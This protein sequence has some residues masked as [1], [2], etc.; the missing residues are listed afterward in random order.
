MKLSILASLENEDIPMTQARF[1]QQKGPRFLCVPSVLSFLV[2][3]VCGSAAAEDSGYAKIDLAV[4]Y[5]VDPS[6]P[7]KPSEF[8]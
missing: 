3:W 5:R 8:Q 7:Q 6:W 4:G 2:V 1:W